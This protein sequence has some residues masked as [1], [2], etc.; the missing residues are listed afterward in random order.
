MTVSTDLACCIALSNF[1]VVMMIVDVRICKDTLFFLG[2]EVLKRFYIP[3][4]IS[5]SFSFQILMLLYILED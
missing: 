3:I 4:S 1:K 5:D 2:Q